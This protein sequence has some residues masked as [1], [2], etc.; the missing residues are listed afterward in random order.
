MQTI[1]KIMSVAL[2]C[3]MLATTSVRTYAGDNSYSIPPETEISD[4]EDSSMSKEKT[5]ITNYDA[6]GGTY[7]YL[8]EVVPESIYYEECIDGVL[9]KGTLQMHSTKATGKITGTRHYEVT[10]KGTLHANSGKLPSA[11]GVNIPK[12]KKDYVNDM[13]NNLSNIDFLQTESLHDLNVTLP[14][15][16]NDIKIQDE[17]E[18]QFITQKEQSVLS[19]VVGTV[20]EVV[21]YAEKDREDVVPTMGFGAIV[22]IEDTNENKYMLSHLGSV[23]CKKGDDLEVGDIVGTTGTTGRASSSMVG[24]SVLTKDKNTVNI[25]FDN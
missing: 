19:P 25:N 1:S 14:T 21:S 11:N 2:V 8:S 3:T 23:D 20:A 24:L 10:F 18:I 15:N 16:T 12:T 5:V 9:W 6:K 17:N 7:K 13:I 4:I 22:I